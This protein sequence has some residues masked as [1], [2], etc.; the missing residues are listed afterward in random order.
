MTPHRFRVWC[1]SW[2]EEEEHGADVVAYDILSHDYNKRERGVVYAPDRVL[3]DAAGAAEAYAD[4]VHSA[5]DGYESSWPLVFRVRS[6][7][8]STAD[9]EVDRE[10]VPEFRASPVKV[11]T[12][13]AEHGA[14]E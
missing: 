2:E 7:D 4:Y 5:R 6:S 10:I 1:L 12:K 14:R 8:G 3:Y 13:P 9:F 11:Q